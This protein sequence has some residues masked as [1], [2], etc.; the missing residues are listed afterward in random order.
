MAI[1]QLFLHAKSFTHKV[2]IAQFDAILN[3]FNLIFLFISKT[4]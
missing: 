1:L 3:D 2:W 4:C